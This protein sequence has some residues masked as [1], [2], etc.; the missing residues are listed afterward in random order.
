M[1]TAHGSPSWRLETRVTARRY[2]IIRVAERGTGY[3]KCPRRYFFS[4]TG[5]GRKRSL[6]MIITIVHLP[7]LPFHPSKLT[8]YFRNITHE[9]PYLTGYFPKF[10]RYLLNLTRWIE[11]ITRYFRNLTREIL[12]LTRYFRNITR[13]IS[14][15]TR[16]FRKIT[17]EIGKLTRYL[18]GVWRLSARWPSTFPIHSAIGIR[19]RHGGQWPGCVIVA[20]I[21]WAWMMS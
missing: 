10:T 13:D 7:P 14:N 21:A 17:G 5:L 8:R 18:R 4:G 9:F 16:E 6:S 1:L 19:P 15:L 2:A 12:K 3:A 20:R 11:N